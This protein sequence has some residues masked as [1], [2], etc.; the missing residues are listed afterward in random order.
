M[1]MAFGILAELEQRH[2]NGRGQH[3]E[4]S[5]QDSVVNLMRVSLRD[6]QRFGRPL[7]R[8]G[9]QLGRNVPGTTYACAPG[10]PNDFV[11]I[12]AQ[13]QMWPAVVGV[14]GRPELAD[15]SRFKT[16]EA[17]WENRAALDAII[18]DWTRH[19]GKH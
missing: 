11:Y 5:M 12:Y 13:P 9:N 17:R 19:R 1:H 3:V 18:A 14:L 2:A 6:H 7:E 8:T 4:V 10:G 16:L 15:D